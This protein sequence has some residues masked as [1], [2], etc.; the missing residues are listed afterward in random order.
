MK[1]NVE[2]LPNRIREWRKKR[3]WSQGVL[4]NKIGVDTVHI[5]NMERGLRNTNLTRLRQ[6]AEAL[7]CNVADLLIAADN[8]YGA[9]PDVEQIFANLS[10][11]GPEARIALRSVA[12]SLGRTDRDSS[13]NE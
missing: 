8:P 10:K 5:S 1:K 9:D 2:D 13:Q 12:K 6:I 7:E 4:G 3:G 11:M